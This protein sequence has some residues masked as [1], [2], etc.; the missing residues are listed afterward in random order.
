MNPMKIK[1]VAF[2]DRIIARIDLTNFGKDYISVLEKHGE[3]LK[4][5][6]DRSQTPLT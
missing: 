5:P 6:L 2:A 3:I 1:S 4:S